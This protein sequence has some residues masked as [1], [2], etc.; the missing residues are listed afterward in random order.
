MTPATPAT[1]SPLTLPDHTQL[2]ESDGTFVKNFQEHPQSILLTESIRPVLEQRHPDHQYCIGQDSG[3]YWRLIDPP[4]KGAESPDW[5][6]VP[7]VPPTLNGKLRR[8]YVLWKEYVAP[9]IAIEFVSGD[10]SEER[11]RTPPSQ[12]QNNKVG[13]FWVYEQAVRIPYYAIY[14][15]EKE[16]VEVY[17]LQDNTYQRITANDRGHYAIP[18]LGVE[19]GIWQGT[20]QN[21]DLPWLRWWDAEGNLLLNGEER[22][23]R[24]QQQAE[25]AQQQAEQA[26]QSRVDSIPRLLSLGL[27]IEQIANAL[28][29]SVEEVR[30]IVHSE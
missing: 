8:S 26:Q 4:E 17:H 29:L 22:A 3:I 5:F 6:Y 16:Q 18:P 12:G 9:L 23:E 14:E 10:G 2:P 30:N 20:Y 11:D 13:K 28:G 21:A 25:R 24:A 1:T 19:L 15:V 7:N 27:E